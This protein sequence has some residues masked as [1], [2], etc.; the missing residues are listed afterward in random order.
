MTEYNTHY[1]PLRVYYEDTDAGGIVYH[2][3]YLNFVERARTESLREAGL[4]QSKLRETH[5]IGFVARHATIDYT[6]PGYLDDALMVETTIEKYGK[7]SFTL[8]QTVKRDEDILATV[9]VKL[10]I[11]DENFKL[12]KISE[13]L[14][15]TFNKVFG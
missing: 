15:Q 11:I 3:N 8:I 12:V 4:N 5:G 14:R 1:F 2:S 10:A 6:K 13:E 7:A 9:K